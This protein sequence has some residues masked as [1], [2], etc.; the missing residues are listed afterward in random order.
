MSRRS[1][2]GTMWSG[3]SKCFRKFILN[4]LHEVAGCRHDCRW[5][6][7]DLGIALILRKLMTFC[8]GWLNESWYHVRNC[9]VQWG[10]PPAVAVIVLNSGG[11]C[12]DNVVETLLLYVSNWWCLT[13]ASCLDECFKSKVSQRVGIIKV[14]PLPRNPKR[15]CST[16]VYRLL[17][18]GLLSVLSNNLVS[19]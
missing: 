15:Q 11:S 16:V 18:P 7:N 5:G 13:L 8:L 6:V 3:N 14:S 17:F 2:D 4:C 10:I 9:P 1:D 12:C 19:T